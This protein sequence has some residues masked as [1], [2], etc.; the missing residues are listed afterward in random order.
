MPPGRGEGD[1]YGVAR[2]VYGLRPA[3]PTVLRTAGPV[4]TRMPAG[5]REGEGAPGPSGPLGR[6]AASVRLTARGADGA[7]V[8]RVRLPGE[9][10]QSVLKVAPVGGLA[11][12]RF[13]R[14][15]EALGRIPA[16]EARA[17][18]LA[19]LLESGGGGGVFWLRVED[20]GPEALRGRWTGERVP[21][22]E[23]LDVA[24]A[25]SAALACL[26]RY[27]VLH[28]DVTEGNVV[29][30]PDRA[31]PARYTL[32]DLDNARHL[33]GTD[34]VTLDR[35]T[36]RR[37]PPE[38]NQ[39]GQHAQLR[40]DVGALGLM[41]AANLMGPPERPWPRGLRDQLRETGL[42]PRDRRHRA[43]ARLVDRAQR[44]P[45]SRRPTGAAF[46]REVRAIRAGRIGLR[47]PRSLVALAV[48]AGLVGVAIS[49]A[50]RHPAIVPPLAFEDAS[51]RW[52]LRAPTADAAEVAGRRTSGFFGFPTLLD[53]G[54]GGSPIVYLPR[55]TRPWTPMPVPELRRDL[56]G[57]FAGGRFAFE[58]APVPD[59]GWEATWVEPIDL[60]GD[61]HRDLLVFQLPLGLPAGGSPGL[62]HLHQALLG[63]AP[64]R[65]AGDLYPDPVE[66]RP[67][68][69]PGEGGQPP[70]VLAGIGYDV[71]VRSSGGRYRAERSPVS[72]LQPLEWI[73]LEGDGLFEVLT[74]NR[75]DGHRLH[76]SRRDPAHPSGWSDTLLAGIPVAGAHAQAR[77]DSVA[78]GDID[79]DGDEDVLPLP[80]DD[81]G[82]VVLRNDSGTLGP[83]PLPGIAL[84]EPGEVGTDGMPGPSI[85]LA[86]LDGDGL[87][88]ILLASGGYERNRAVRPKVWRNEGDLRFRRVGLP[89]SLAR[90]QDGWRFLVLDAEGDMALAGL[91]V[92]PDAWTS[93]ALR[94]WRRDAATFA[95]RGSAR[96][97]GL[98]RVIGLAHARGSLAA[99][100]VDPPGL[101]ILDAGTLE[102]TSRVSLDT[103][104]PCAVEAVP[105]GWAVSVTEGFA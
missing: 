86:D 69:L 87:P 40:Y 90:A 46:A 44:F 37:M 97:E 20:A 27:R 75:R 31:G 68:A 52:G 92:G 94:I 32:V 100:S 30:R 61:A 49:Q 47:R 70:V 55:S 23:A 96:I 39:L 33:A 56:V 50:L 35:G 5:T 15:A 3:G 59:P 11:E 103:A 64:Y 72:R 10:G 57:R 21:F 85:Q 99:C 63:P 7:G 16:T 83:V 42:D 9:E 77:G 88:E 76:L 105:G 19:P 95:V 58:V 66:G 2:V 48:A 104:G 91:A 38:A 17:C 84:M 18:H 73:D 45:P 24:E 4:G 81:R 1:L 82:P 34:E 14:E 22:E 13:R 6:F 36:Q 80:R 74:V 79:G 62:P 102:E 54:P 29:V 25:V 26:H 43:F 41:L 53:P 71:E 65:A 98:G 101:A 89:P 28:G 67:F 8:F 78:V 93:S 51:D 12:G 60:D